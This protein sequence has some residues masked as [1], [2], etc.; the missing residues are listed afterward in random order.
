VVGLSLLWRVTVEM[1]DWHGWH[2][3]ALRRLRR[4]L[5][6]DEE[7][8]RV[9]E[10]WPWL[11]RLARRLLPPSVMVEVVADGPGRAAKRAEDAVKRSLA[12]VGRP[13]TVAVRI[14]STDG[15]LAGGNSDASPD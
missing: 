15:E 14:V 4:S 12:R 1:P 10:V 6:R 8:V 2:P 3:L 13:G 9:V 7:I 11:D 5:E